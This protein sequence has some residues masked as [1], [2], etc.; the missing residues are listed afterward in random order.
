MKLEPAAFG[1]HTD[2]GVQL[3]A[4][5]TPT[6]FTWSRERNETS[7]L[8]VTA[9]MQRLGEEIVPLKHWL[10]CWHGQSLQWIGPVLVAD[11]SRQTLKVDCRDVSWFMAGTRTQTT[12]QWAVSDVGP[13]AADL[14]REMLTMR[15][16]RADPVVL[17]ATRDARYD[18]TVKAEL[19]TMAQD[20]AELS[21][22]GLRWTVVRGRPVLGDQ[23]VT[24]IAELAD[25][26]DLS[27]GAMIRR[28][29]AQFA[30]DVR[31]QGKNGAT[32]ARI[33]VA[34][35][36]IQ[37]IVSL[38]DLH[39][40]ANIRAA[41]EQ[42]V[43]RSAVLRDELIVPSDATLSPDA[44]V[45][46]DELVPGVHLTVSAL[47]LRTVLRL[48]QVTVSGSAAGTTVAVRLATP[49]VLTDVEQAGGQVQQ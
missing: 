31:L 14:W 29:G 16:L 32:V 38:D 48:D 1:L 18:F 40:V 7:R 43:Q 21:K 19:R 37:R 4:I 12:R 41:A 30:N 24:P 13:I 45:S 47:G 9:P 27:G 11:R 3:G 23:P 34:G 25:E 33:P 17:P 39:G 42:Y 6:G 5:E 35:L 44:P 49:E 46:L 28:S 20:M 22:M 10:S 8:S 2:D 15:Q 26:V 36:Q